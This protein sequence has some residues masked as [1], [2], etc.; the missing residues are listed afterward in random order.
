M[1]LAIETAVEKVGVALGDSRGVAASV[2]LSSDRRHAESLTPMIEFACAHAGVSL[3]DVSAVAVDIGPGLFTG[4]RVGIATAEMLAWSLDVPVVGVCSLDIVAS[5][6]WHAEDTVVAALDA[7]RGEIYWAMYKPDVVKKQMIALTSPVVSSPEDMIVEV[8][9]R[10]EPVWCVGSGF[11]RYRNDVELITRA[12]FAPD[13]LATPSAEVLVEI[14]VGKIARD[15]TIEARDIE[16]MYLR[17]PDAE[18]NWAV[19]EGA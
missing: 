3:S 13:S 1:I 18:I 5:S 15:E 12:Q 2:S 8:N 19:R 17:A 7:R 10:G 11:V 4:M 6:L 14:A 16:P 9:D